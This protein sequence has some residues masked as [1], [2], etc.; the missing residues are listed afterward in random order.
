MA[1]SEKLRRAIVWPLVTLSLIWIVFA[2]EY[3]SGSNWF[4]YG[5]APRKMHAIGGIFTAPFLHGDIGHIISNSIPLFTLMALILFFYPRVAKSV[6]LMLYLGTGVAMW[7]FADPEVIFQA[8]PKSNYHIGASGVVY[9]MVT[10]LAWNGIFRRNLKAIAIALVVVFYYG[11][12]IWGVLPLQER[13]SWEGHLLG[14]L[15]GIFAAYWYR[16]RIED[17]EKRKPASWEIEPDEE[18]PFLPPD[19]FERKKHER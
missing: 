9:G 17:D 7:L 14:A 16:D 19:T 3:I 5:I 13:V 12:L 15:V 18:H 6:L 4:I 10:F 2:L 8:Y 11:G 1:I